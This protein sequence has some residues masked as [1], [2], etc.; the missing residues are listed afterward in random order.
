MVIPNKYKTIAL[1]VTAVFYSSLATATYPTIDGA[2]LSQNIKQNIEQITSRIME[3]AR[4]KIKREIQKKLTIK[5]NESAAASDMTKIKAEQD[6]ATSIRNDELAKQLA[7]IPDACEDAGLRAYSRKAAEMVENKIKNTLGLGDDTCLVGEHDPKSKAITERKSGFTNPV[8]QE[9]LVQADAQATIDACKLLLRE[10]AEVTDPKLLDNP[11][12]LAE[13]SLCHASSLVSQSVLPTYDNKAQYLAAVQ[14]VKLMTEPLIRK[15]PL[16]SLDA[17]SP[18]GKKRLLRE[19]RKDLLIGLAQRTLYDYIE[20]RKPEEFTEEMGGDLNATN[21]LPSP[22]ME[23][24]LFNSKR[25]NHKDGEW[26]KIVSNTHPEKDG[27]NGKKYSMTPYQLQREALM[28]DGFLAHIA[29][30]Q[31]KSMLKQEV[32]QAAILSTHVNKVK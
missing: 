18:T 21:T 5:E 4:E 30:L 7:G 11:R 8:E 29:V 17:V 25:Y 24:E 26:I 20:W 9:K 28:I 2:N 16:E 14:Q 31:Y 10:G 12:L 32:L 19:F 3:E 6:L 15:K 27:P 1:A 22:M 13:N 23:L